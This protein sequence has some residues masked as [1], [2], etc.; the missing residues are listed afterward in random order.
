MKFRLEM[1]LGKEVVSTT[2]KKETGLEDPE[3]Y[4]VSL[5][6]YEKEHGPADQSLIVWETID[7]VR[8]AG[9]I[10]AAVAKLL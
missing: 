8:R 4:W 2:Q 10:L 6:V 9:V 3:E 5:D 7:G 1:N